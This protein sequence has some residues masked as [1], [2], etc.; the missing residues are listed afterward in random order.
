M[1]VFATQCG[2]YLNCLLFYWLIPES[3]CGDAGWA[4]AEPGKHKDSFVCVGRPHLQ[5]VENQVAD[6]TVFL[7]PLEET[8]SDLSLSGQRMNG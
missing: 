6:M 5:P 1:Y 8:G 4:A 2:V 3:S 7:R